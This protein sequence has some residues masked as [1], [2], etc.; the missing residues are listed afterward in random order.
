[1]FELK[2][3]ENI[4]KELMKEKN[5][6]QNDLADKS[7]LTRAYITGILSGGRKMSPKTIEKLCKA[8]DADKETKDL[9]DFY[10]LFN[11]APAQIQ[12]LF[13]DSFSKVEKLEAE[14]R[15]YKKLEK[16]L[17]LVKSMILLDDD[18]KKI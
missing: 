4:I 16:Y 2:R 14:L 8:L 13:F 7:G 12:M 17:E 9:I 1:M 18:F 11:Q 6:N 10:E 15:K 5:F 3:T